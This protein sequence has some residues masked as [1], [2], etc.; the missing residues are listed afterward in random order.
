MG[1]SSTKLAPF[2]IDNEALEALEALEDLKDEIVKQIHDP[3]TSIMPESLNKNLEQFMQIPDV[4]RE[5]LPFILE[6]FEL[7]IRKNLSDQ[8][9]FIS[10]SFYS[11]TK[12][13]IMSYMGEIGDELKK[14]YDN[15]PKTRDLLNKKYPATS[16]ATDGPPKKIAWARGPETSR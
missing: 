2:G 1:N 8:A 10:D 5:E 12:E 4:K 15:S 13:P 6:I 11:Q 14:T 9:E 3:Y 7:S 16:I